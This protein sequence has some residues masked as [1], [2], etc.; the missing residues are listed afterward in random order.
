MKLS[1][2]IIVTFAI[3]FSGHLEALAFWGSDAR[4]NVSGLDVAAGYDVNTVTTISGTVVTTPAKIDQREHT[5]MIVATPQGTTTVLLGPW[6]YWDRQGFSISKDQVISITGSRAQGKDGSLYIFAQRID[7]KTSGITITLRSE[8][9]SP[10]WSRGGS[11][12]SNEGSQNSVRGT[13]A[14]S[15][16]RG[17]NMRGGGRR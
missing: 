2:F 6:V 8:T 12:S 10:M 14:G 9:G 7:N 15:G 16:F 13:G 5:Q 1:F 11:G 4:Q 3:I 17:G